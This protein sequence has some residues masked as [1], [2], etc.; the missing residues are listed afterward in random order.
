[1]ID[2]E[3]GDAL[4]NLHYFIELRNKTVVYGLTDEYGL[5][6]MARTSEPEIVRCYWGKEARHKI[7]RMNSK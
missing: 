6:D 1:M 2:S 5:T 7:A 3:T 4:E